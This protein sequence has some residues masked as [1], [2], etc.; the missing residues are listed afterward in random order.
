[1][2]EVPV[3]SAR[4]VVG[5]EVG[6]SFAGSLLPRRFHVATG[7]VHAGASESALDLR[8]ALPRRVGNAT[9]DRCGPTSPR[10]THR[11]SGCTAH[12][13]SED[14]SSSALALRGSFGRIVTGSFPVD[15]LPA[16]LL[17]TRTGAR[18]VI[19][20]QVSGLP[21]RCLSP[22]EATPAWYAHEVKE[23]RRVRSIPPSA[24]QRQMGGLR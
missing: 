13:E 7:A 1:L 18:P 9:Y 3:H 21:R 4:Q 16:A 8:H 22:E 6:R 11:L 24:S 14:A 23:P 12:M 10:G 19:P 2:S 5:S 20:K 15:A 17:L